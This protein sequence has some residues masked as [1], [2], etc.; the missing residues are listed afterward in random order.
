MDVFQ[1]ASTSTSAAVAAGPP[2]ARR[3]CTGDVFPLGLAVCA[4]VKVLRRTGSRVRAREQLHAA[5]ETFDQLGARPWAELAQ[6]ELGATG[7]RARRREPSTANDL[8]PQELQISL[9]LAQGRTT[10][11]AAAAVFLSPKTIEYHLRNVYRKLGVNSREQL[12]EAS[13]SAPRPTGAVALGDVRASV[14]GARAGPGRDRGLRGL[15]PSSGVPCLLRR[16]SRSHFQ[17]SG[18]SKTRT[19]TVFSCSS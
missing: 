4:A 7:E 18:V 5:V 13:G 12:A 17:C 10:R 8:T 16:W 19:A 11:E 9:M 2:T 6:A 1:A 15:G 14:G 3:E